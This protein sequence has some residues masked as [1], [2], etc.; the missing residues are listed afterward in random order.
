MPGETQV[1][2]EPLNF[3]AMNIY[4][5]EEIGPNDAFY[6]DRDDLEGCVILTDE[7]PTKNHQGW[8][9][10]GVVFKLENGKLGTRVGDN[11]FFCE[12]KISPFY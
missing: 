5:I 9:V 12:V 2:F 6:D 1:H 3:N 4:L 10:G 8:S 7:C 11:Y